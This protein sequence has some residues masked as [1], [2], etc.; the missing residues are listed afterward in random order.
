MDIE[1]I[2]AKLSD[3]PVLKN[4]MQLYLYDFSEFEHIEI[5]NQG[6]FEYRFFD[7]YFAEKE[8][9]PFL[10]RYKKRIAG[11]ALVNSHSVT[12]EAKYSIAEFFVMRRYRRNAI[13]RYVATSLFDRFAG[14]WEVRQTG[15]N[16]IAQI[17]WLK[18]IKTYTSDTFKL[19][20]NGFG[21]WNGPIQVFKSNTLQ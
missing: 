19:F 6:L 8:R 3:K 1:I 20:E 4:L 10:I 16:S 9:Y 13:G 15:N 7:E 5:N 2:E 14:Y 12:G 21:G 17:F 18:I 11:F